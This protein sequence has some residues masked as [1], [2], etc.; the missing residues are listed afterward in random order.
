MD[1]N[2]CE[3]LDPVATAPPPAGPSPLGGTIPLVGGSLERA[4]IDSYGVS[5]PGPLPLYP[6][7]EPTIQSL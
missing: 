2:R 7:L 4:S 5:Q 3:R 1:L 6:H